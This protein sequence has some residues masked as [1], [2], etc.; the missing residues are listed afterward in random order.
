MSVYSTGTV[1][2]SQYGS[3]SRLFVKTKT[4][5][6]ITYNKNYLNLGILLLETP[7]IGI[8]RIE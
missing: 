2:F 3:G 8:S 7:P 5:K 1:P 4:L 6:K